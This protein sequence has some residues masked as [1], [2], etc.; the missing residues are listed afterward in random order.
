M[1]KNRC[2]WGSKNDLLI[3]YHD[4]EWGLPLHDDRRLF[5]ALLLDG[6]QAGLN[7]LIMLQK[8]ESFRE[9]FDDFD[10]EKI[11]QYSEGKFEELL[12][13]KGI[14]R[15]RLKIGAAIKN[16]QAFLRV[17]EEFGGFSK[18]IWGFVKGEPIINEWHNIR[19]IP[20]KTPLA[21][22]ISKDLKKRG[23]SFVGATIIYAFMQGVGIVNDHTVDCFRHSEVR[24]T[25]KNRNKTQ[26]R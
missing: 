10:P 4:E 12:Q 25:G 15:N 17:Q 22:E 11:S 18:Y 19:D 1:E 20:A 14:I 6:F 24:N 5:E 9:A 2:D 23:F 8:R 21:E 26:P 3:R 16:A 13:N 7:W